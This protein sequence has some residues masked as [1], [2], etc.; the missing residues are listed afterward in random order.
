[1]TL[2]EVTEV[3]EGYQWRLIQKARDTRNLA[4]I[5]TKLWAKKSPN[6]PEQL[7]RL[8]GDD[9]ELTSDEDVKQIFEN[10]RKQGVDV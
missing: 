2:G 10:L 1:M 6:S 9:T 8:P 4:F 5:M 3:S 7:W